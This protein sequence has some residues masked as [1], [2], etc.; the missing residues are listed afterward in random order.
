[1][2]GRRLGDVRRGGSKDRE[3]TKV[4]YAY[5]FQFVAFHQYSRPDGDGNDFK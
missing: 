5:G 4:R 3:V 1:M 2:G